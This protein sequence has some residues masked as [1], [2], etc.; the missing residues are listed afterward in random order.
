MTIQPSYDGSVNVILNDGLN[1][2]RMIN[3]RFS[4]TGMDTY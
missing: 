3:S 4:V 2:P 1:Q